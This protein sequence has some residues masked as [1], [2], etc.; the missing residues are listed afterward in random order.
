MTPVDIGEVV[1]LVIVVISGLGGML[2]A[3]KK[4]GK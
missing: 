1:F 4:E 3:V 2:W